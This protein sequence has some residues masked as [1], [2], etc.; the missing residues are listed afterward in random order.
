M[1]MSGSDSDVPP[2]RKTKRAMSSG[3]DGDF[4]PASATNG[5]LYPLE[6]KYKDSADRK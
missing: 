3:S 1:D 2:A 5:G 4:N 6:G